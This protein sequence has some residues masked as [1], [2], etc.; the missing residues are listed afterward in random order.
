MNNNYKIL[1]CPDFAEIN[2]DFLDYITKYTNLLTNNPQANDYDG[3]PFQYANFPEKFGYNMVHF[4]KA[5]PLFVKWC[6][7]YG[8][9]VKDVYFSLAWYTYSKGYPESSCPI[10]LDRP[11]VTWKLNW[12]ILNM[13]GTAVRFF[14]L[15]DST[16][17]VNS[18][19]TRPGI[20]GSKDRDYHQLQYKD[21]VEIDRHIF[22]DTPVIM[23][24]QVPH[25][26]GFYD[27]NHS[28]PR[29]GL[30]VMFVNEPLHLL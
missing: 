4:I 12:P 10:H 3:T 28:F 29:I 11:P 8:M 16:L 1:D 18:L 6:G 27:E 30:Q 5:N 22:N 7:S 13:N 24:G 19:V 2:A 21:F 26:V 14:E 23:N 9:K 25:D 17:D 15:K 20:P